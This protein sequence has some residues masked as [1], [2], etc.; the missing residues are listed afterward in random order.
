MP[1]SRAIA[2]LSVLVATGLATGLG[3]ASVSASTDVPPAAAVAGPTAEG[4]GSA[5]AEDAVTEYLSAFAA[6]DLAGAT[7]AFA[8]ETFVEHYDFEAAIEWQRFY[9][10]Y[11]IGI[12]LPAGDPLNTAFNVEQ[13]RATV[14]NQILN[15]YF[16]LL[17]P[18]LDRTQG[19]MVDDAAEFT[20]S[21]SAAMSSGSLAGLADF[22]FVA[23]E[24]IDADAAEL[25]TGPDVKQRDERNAVLGADESLAVAVRT[26]AAGDEVTLVFDAVRYGDSWWLESLGGRFALLLNVDVT[27]GGVMRDDAAA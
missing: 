22:E 19:Q 24:D 9:Q 21:L 27:S 6:G 23:L 20:E 7:A 25:Y 4:P 17:N 15:Q 10:S 2:T 12:P 1:R 16:A 11:G 8:V 3:A 26:T 5:S 13:R 18:E 14:V